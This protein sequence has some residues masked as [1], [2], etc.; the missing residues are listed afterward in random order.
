MSDAA[1]AVRGL[2]KKFSKT[3]RATMR[4]GAIDLAHTALGAQH[5]RDHLRRGEFWAIR[6]LSF[7]LLRGEWLG[8]VGPNGAG[9]ST[10]L[11]LLSGILRPDTGSIELHGRVCSLIELGAGFHPMLSGRENI[12]L[13]GSMMGFARSEI[14]ERIAAIIEFAGI[15]DFIDT[16]VKFYSSGMHARL[17]FSVAIH[18]EPDILL[19]DEVLAVGDRSFQEKCM[20]A[21]QLLRSE[22]HA[23]LMVTHSLYRVEALCD[24]ALWL[25]ETGCKMIGPALEVVGAFLDDQDRRVEEE[26]ARGAAP[27]AGEPAPLILEGI[28]VLA[29]DGSPRSTFAP[30][31]SFTVR[32]L[33]RAREAIERPY[34]NLR[35]LDRGFGIID[36]SMLVDGSPIA[37]FDEGPGAVECHFP[38]LPLAPR[39]YELALFV[40]GPDGV[41][42]VIPLRNIGAFRIAGPEP[43]YAA[44]G[45]PMALNL[46]RQGCPLRV[47]TEWS[48]S[49]AKLARGAAR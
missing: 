34:F 35:V 8:V 45:G 23:V 15:P 28:E 40:R 27:A 20:R 29:D 47:E 12:Y 1:I 38:P 43:T 24:R 48:F 26:T 32:L 25:E 11:K 21:M 16:P 49:P 2:S 7:D 36:A 9:K 6:D 3:L 4:N 14:N 41:T 19:V 18:F 22:R 39:T 5:P 31:E 46:I 33:L 42:P 13:Q 30:N 10:L 44:L 37:L 17:G